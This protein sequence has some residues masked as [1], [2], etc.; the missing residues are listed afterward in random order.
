VKAQPPSGKPGA[1][2]DI[3]GTNLTGATSVTFNGVTAVF[4]VSSSS[5]IRATAPAGATTGEIQV[6]TPGGTLSSSAPFEVL[7]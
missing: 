6:V 2:I 3:L 5:L 1:V 7:P 4:E